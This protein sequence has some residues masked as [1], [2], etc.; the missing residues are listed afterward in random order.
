MGCVADGVYCAV[1]RSILPTTEALLEGSN[2][3]LASLDALFFAEEPRGGVYAGGSGADSF[4]LKRA[5][6][7]PEEVRPLCCCDK[8]RT[9]EAY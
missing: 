8:G 3:T 5:R 1:L 2:G 4:V 6:L 9:E 7:E